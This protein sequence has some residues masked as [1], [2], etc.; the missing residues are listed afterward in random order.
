MLIGCQAVAKAKEEG[1]LDASVL[2]AV[3]FCAPL[4]GNADLAT[5]EIHAELRKARSS[6]LDGPLY[7]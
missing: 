2:Q 1:V 4:S 5:A 6:T 7:P 3:I